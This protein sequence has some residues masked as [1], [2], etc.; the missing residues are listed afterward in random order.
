MAKLSF[1]VQKSEFKEYLSLAVLALGKND[2]DIITKYL[3]FHAFDSVVEIHSTDK[4][5][6][7][8]L[9]FKLANPIKEEIRF[10]V[11]GAKLNDFIKFLD[12][13]AIEFGYDADTK[14]LTVYSAPT[15]TE[16]KLTSLNP[17]DFIQFDKDFEKAK[18]IGDL[19]KLEVLR[20]LSFVGPFIGNSES[21][22]QFTVLELKNNT[23]IA[24]NG[25]MLGAYKSEY[26]DDGVFWR[27]RGSYVQS[28]VKFLKESKLEEFYLYESSNSYYLKLDNGC[29]FGFVK[30]ETSLPN[31][32]IPYASDEKNNF[33]VEKEAFFRM[34]NRLKFAL[35]K[36]SFKMNFKLSGKGTEGVLLGTA[37]N[38]QGA[39]S[40]EKLKVNREAGDTDVNL[41]INYQHLLSSVNQ[42]SNPVLDCYFEPSKKYFKI[43]EK[44]EGDSAIAVITIMRS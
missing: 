42:F 4:S 37:V 14:I 32:S 44:N 2:T 16:L 27:I 13:G 30:T 25:R 34:I 33:K 35:N 5:V 43:L 17:D 24:S 1:T 23:W 38:D 7:A 9:G 3:Y 8:K 36:D 26:T 40:T 18:K 15:E 39:E 10:T 6:M 11:E 41:A 29:Y 19:K 22:P 20:G 21:E 12:E 28:V 31:V